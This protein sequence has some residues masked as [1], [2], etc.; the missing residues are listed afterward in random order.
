M[1]RPRP[2]TSVGAVVVH[3]AELLL[4]QRGRGAAVGQWSVPGGRVEFG[5]TLSAAVEREVAE[6]TGLQV[7]CGPFIG[8]VER[9]GPDYHYVI[10]D[11][12]ATLTGPPG[13][14]HAADDAQAARWVPLTEVQQVDLV[15]GMAEF[16]VEHG[17]IPRP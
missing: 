6:E 5:E 10:L 17:I 13:P 8:H 11:F 1:S 4:I 9:F 2:E 12:H 16:L 3:E 15:A 14:L 7:A